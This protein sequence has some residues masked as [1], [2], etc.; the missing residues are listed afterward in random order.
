M[1]YSPAMCVV[2]GG[3][4]LVDI[5]AGFPK[6]KCAAMKEQV[7]QTSPCEIGHHQVGMP[8]MLP[9][10]KDGHDIDVFEPGDDVGFPPKTSQ[11][12]FVHFL[13]HCGVGEQDFNSNVT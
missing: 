12:I 1:N 11:K 9:I 5:D 6:R 8:I 13:A 3:G 10:F 7:T 2:E 4:S